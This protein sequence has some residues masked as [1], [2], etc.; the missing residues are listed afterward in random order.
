MDDYYLVHFFCH[1][2]GPLGIHCIFFSFY[3]HAPV[4]FLEHCFTVPYYFYFTISFNRIIYITK[5][6]NVTYPWEIEC[7]QSSSFKRVCE[8]H[9]I[10]I[11]IYP[12]SHHSF[13]SWILYR[14]RPYQL[15]SF[16]LLG[17]IVVKV[18]FWLLHYSELCLIV[19]FDILWV[20]NVYGKVKR[21]QYRNIWL[22]FGHGCQ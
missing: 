1:S 4:S 9:H 17:Y 8:T 3:F 15:I 10:Y 11:Y 14:T 7:K 16:I 5:L 18:L 12:W 6:V 2:C 22:R 21:K 13:D 20:C 19:P